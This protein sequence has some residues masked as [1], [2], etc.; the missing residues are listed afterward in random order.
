MS[1]SVG[2]SLHTVGPDIANDLEATVLR[3]TKGTFHV[4]ASVIKVRMFY[5]DVRVFSISLK[6]DGLSLSWRRL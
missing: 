1:M 4:L 2:S 6:Y 5:S 3:L